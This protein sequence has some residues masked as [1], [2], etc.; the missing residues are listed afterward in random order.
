MRKLSGKFHFFLRFCTRK[1]SE[2]YLRSLAAVT[3]RLTPLWRPIFTIKAVTGLHELKN[4]FEK[5]SSFSFHYRPSTKLGEGN[6]FTGVCHSVRGWVGRG[7]L[8]YQVPS[9]GWVSLVPRPFWGYLWY[10]V[11]SRDGYAWS[12]VP[13]GGDGY[14]HGV[15]V[16]LGVGMWVPT[17]LVPTSSGGHRSGQYASYWNAFLFESIFLPSPWQIFKSREKQSMDE[18]VD[19]G[20]NS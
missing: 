10:Q 14:V 8:G 18:S 17:P 5:L 4:I 13:S 2:T 12:Q 3:L 11:P 19:R 20:E 15:G 1:R 6:V 7:Y 9:R 16:C